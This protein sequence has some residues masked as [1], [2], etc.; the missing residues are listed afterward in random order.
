MRRQV[1]RDVDIVGDKKTTRSYS[2]A[3]ISLCSTAIIFAWLWFAFALGEAYEEECR[4]RMADT[5]EVGFFVMFGV[6]PLV[7]VIVGA[8]VALVVTTRGPAVYR[9]KVVAGVFAAATAA[10]VLFGWGMSNWTLFTHFA[11][12]ANCY[13]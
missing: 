8:L 13:A 7:L 4:A 12:G 10:G 3:A 9:L 1:V 6:V 11:I 2:S 5:G